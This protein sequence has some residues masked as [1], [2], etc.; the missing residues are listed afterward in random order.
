MKYVYLG[1]GSNIG[2]REC[3]LDQA[4]YELSAQEGVELLQTSSY[5][6][7]EPVGVKKQPSFLNAVCKICTILSP[8]E[9]LDITVS[10][11]KKLGRDLKG[12]GDPRTIDIDILF[13]GDDVISEDDLIIPHPFV[14]ERN[15]VLTPLIELNPSLEHPVLHET[16][17]ELK[18][19]TFGY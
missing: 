2:D 17:Q 7:T 10:V 4:L 13:Y 8:R 5:H 9:L 11:E 1:L 19:R 12:T 18:A 6:E 16:V 15:F 14:H 3:F